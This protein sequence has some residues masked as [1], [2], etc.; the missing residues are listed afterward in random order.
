MTT[1]PITQG[2]LE[3]V[4]GE[5]ARQPTRHQ[6]S[7]RLWPDDGLPARRGATRGVNPLEPCSLFGAI[8]GR[9]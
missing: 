9:R 2:N 1:N 6:G 5:E 7:R 8:L 4:E 3:P